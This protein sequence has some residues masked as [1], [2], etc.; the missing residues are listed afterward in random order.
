[1]LKKER[2]RLIVASQKTL[3][4]AIEAKDSYTRGHTDR[5]AGYTALIG[6]RLER[7]LRNFAYGLPNLNWS[8]QLHDIGKIGIPDGILSKPDSLDSQEWE[9]VREIYKLGLKHG[10]KLAAISGVNG[11]FSDEDIATVKKLALKARKKAKKPGGK[12]A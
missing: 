8:A 3:I 6:K 11:V 1:M 12:K 4:S 2:I 9:K 5:V 7:P 10:M